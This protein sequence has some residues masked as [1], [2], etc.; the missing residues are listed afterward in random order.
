[1][2]VPDDDLGRNETNLEQ[3]FDLSVV[4]TLCIRERNCTNNFFT[5]NE[6]V[7]RFCQE[8]VAFITDMEAMFPR[9]KKLRLR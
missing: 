8:P 4:V 1:M 7:T 3:I 5:L 6:V 2:E 9:E